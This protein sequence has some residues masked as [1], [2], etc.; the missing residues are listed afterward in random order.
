MKIIEIIFIIAV[1][2]WWFSVALKFE[3]KQHFR[4]INRYIQ[5]TTRRQFVII[6]S[7]I[8]MTFDKLTKESNAYFAQRHKEEKMLQEICD[9]TRSYD[10]LKTFKILNPNKNNA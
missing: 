4:S 3:R 2:I 7:S 5:R 8:D 6:K 10:D 9:G 1:N